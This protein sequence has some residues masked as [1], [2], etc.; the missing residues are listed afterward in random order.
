MKPHIR[1]SLVIPVYNEERYIGACLAAI[2]RLSAKPFE[3]I[4]VDN[5]STDGSMA[6]VRTFP[7]ARIVPEPRR[8]LAFARDAGF[9][10]A[11]GDVIGRIDA[12]TLLDPDWIAKV[13]RLFA[14]PDVAAVSGAIDYYDISLKRLVG[15]FDLYFRRL[16]AWYLRDEAFLFGGN[17]AMRRSAWLKVSNELCH[18]RELHE[19]LDIAAHLSLQGAHEVR[20]APELHAEVSARCVDDSFRHFLFYMLASPRTYA[21]HGL[22]RQRVMYLLIGFLTVLYWPIRLLYFA[23]ESESG[24]FSL[25]AFNRARAHRTLRR[26]PVALDPAE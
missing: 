13:Q 25:R 20:F 23:S 6:I 26:S 22:R 3:V 21:A 12:D 1:V 16:F 9:N 14:D 5:G 2:A 19:D 18:A 24:G 17:M 11:R 15:W 7:F 10:A 4:V 8:G